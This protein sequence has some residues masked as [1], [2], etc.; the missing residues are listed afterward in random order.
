MAAGQAAHLGR[1]VATALL[2]LAAIRCGQAG[3]VRSA[4]PRRWCGGS[5]KTVEV[6]LARSYQKVGAR[7][8]TGLARLI[9]SGAL[10]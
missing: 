10:P 6:H 1:E 8:R 7:S 5:P 9:H 2:A 4:L 3:Q